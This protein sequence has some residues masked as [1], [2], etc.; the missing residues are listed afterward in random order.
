MRIPRWTATGIATGALLV[1]VNLGCAAR[2]PAPLQVA[3]TWTAAAQR[4][5]TAANRAET[6]ANQ[7]E[8]AAAR[9]ETAAQRAEDAAA[10]M[11][12]MMA[13]TMMK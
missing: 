1:T 3:D 13:K 8:A 5:E 12:A 4:A 7:A 11:E 9:V 2:Q 10:R 6:A